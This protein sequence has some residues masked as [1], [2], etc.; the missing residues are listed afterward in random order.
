MKHKPLLCKVDPLILHPKHQQMP[1][2][3]C[4]SVNLQCYHLTHKE[5][6]FLHGSWL[7]F[8]SEPRVD[9]A[10]FS[11]CLFSYCLIDT[12]EWARNYH[13]QTHSLPGSSRNDIRPKCI[14]HLLTVKCKILFHKILSK[15]TKTYRMKSGMA[16]AMYF[17]KGQ[18][19]LKWLYISWNKSTTDAV[20]SDKRKMTFH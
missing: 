12:V 8:I 19:F 17:S 2:F 7:H 13:F 5:S 18:M 16:T 4:S 9:I 20:R 1:S 11:Q 15:R 10:A 3:W 14:F 6:T